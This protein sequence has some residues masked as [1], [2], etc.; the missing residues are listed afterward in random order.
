[1]LRWE[2]VLDLT[3]APQ[4]NAGPLMD[5]VEDVKRVDY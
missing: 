2:V 3:L 1:M 5:L 4:K